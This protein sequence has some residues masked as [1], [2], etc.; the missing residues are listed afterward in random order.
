MGENS[1]AIR[2]T[3]RLCGSPDL[4]TAI[5]LPELPIMSPNVGRADTKGI[6]APADVNQCKS[7]GFLQLSA[8]VDPSLQYRDYR[9]VTGLS[10]GLRE[11]FGGFIDQLAES[12]DIGDDAFV[13][14]I[15]SNDGSVLSFAKQRGARVVG[16]DPAVE[17]AQRATKSGIPTLPEFFNETLARR[18]VGEHGRADVVICNNAIANIDDLDSVFRGIAALLKPGGR[19]SLETQYAVDMIDRTLLDVIYH[20]HI[21]YFVVSPMPA[22]LARF[23]LELFDAERIAPKGGSIRFH[24]QTV[25]GVRPISGRVTELIDEERA[26]DGFISGAPIAAFN[27]RISVIRKE[28]RERLQASKEKSGRAVAFGASVGSAALVQF[29]GLADILDA[30]FDDTPLQNSMRVGP[31]VVPVLSGSQILNEPAVDVAVL[32]W[33]YAHLIADRHTNLLDKGGSF[34]RVLPDVSTVEPKS[35]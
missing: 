18:L 9:Y 23:G 22:F 13:V 29:L 19:C 3:C 8:V 24:I 34:F 25:G 10:V 15:G 17:I 27:E 26:E 12:G 32:A 5:A 30:V 20:E 28:V 4:A 14:E 16:I 7:C 35:N 1:F 6:M 2:E 21:S 33:R 11:H 31:R